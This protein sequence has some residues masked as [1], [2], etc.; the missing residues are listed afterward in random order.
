ML[1][2]PTINQVGAAWALAELVLWAGRPRWIWLGA[3]LLVGV[4]LVLDVARSPAPLLSSLYGL[5][6]PIGLP[7]LLGLA[8]RAGRELNRQAEQR[9]VAEQHSRESESRAA[10]ADE[11]A[12]I[13]R[14][15]HDVVAH[16]VASMVLRAGVARHVLAG[17]DPRMT[18]VLGGELTTGPS[19]TGWLVR[20]ELPLGSAA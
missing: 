16:H 11:R 9:A 4:Y 7:V 6:V 12:A 18:E 17:A 8:V 19:G 13:A 5:M 14:E 20:T 3:G 10:R 15:L 2:D 1:D